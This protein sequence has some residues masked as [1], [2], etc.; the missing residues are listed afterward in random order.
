MNMVYKCILIKYLYTTYLLKSKFR[1]MWTE[2]RTDC[3]AFETANTDTNMFNIQF[4]YYNGFKPISYNILKGLTNRDITV[5]A[6]STSP[7]PHTVSSPDY[8]NRNT[9]NCIKSN[10][11]IY[12]MI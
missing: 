9:N 6:V 11:S 4:L 7:I 8:R 10:S 12:T 1:I 3:L 5:A 2:R